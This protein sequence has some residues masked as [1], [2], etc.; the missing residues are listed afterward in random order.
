MNIYRIADVTFSLNTL[1]NYTTQMVKDYVADGTPQFDITIT[2]EDIAKEKALAPDFH[3][4]YLE[5]L[6]VYRKLCEKMTADYNGFIFHSSAI[7]VDGEAYLFTAPSGTGKSTHA[8]LWR[9]LLGDRATMINDDKPIIRYIDGDFYVYGTAWDGKHR[10]SA[11]KR[12]KIK[13]ICRIHQS[14]TNTISKIS[15]KEIMPTLLNQTLRPKNPA[16][17]MNLLDLIEKLVNKVDLYG[18]GCN[19]SLD[20]A[21]LSYE[22]MSGKKLKEDIL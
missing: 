4:A 15:V 7:D 16:D 8:A 5:S 18:L 6:A 10:L 14:P 9:K 17:M 19:I 11:N 2:Q 13:A 1:Y 21:K 12:S 3:E 22:T 20:A